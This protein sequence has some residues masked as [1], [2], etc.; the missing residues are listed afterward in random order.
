VDP[1]ERAPEESPVVHDLKDI[2]AKNHRGLELA[3]DGNGKPGELLISLVRN[4]GSART[5]EELSHTLK[6]APAKARYQIPWPEF[7]SVKSP[8]RSPLGFD[9]LRIDGT[10][11]DGSMITME[12]VSLF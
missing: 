9:G 12:D 6:Y 10:R 11:A 7:I 5:E 2:H 1:E 3:I 4:T 8:G